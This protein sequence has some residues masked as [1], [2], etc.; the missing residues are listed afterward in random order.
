MP[1]R[2]D[3]PSY[4]P[5]R[6]VFDIL[7]EQMPVGKY[8][9]LGYWTPTGYWRFQVGNDAENVGGFR[10]T[11]REQATDP[12]LAIKQWEEFRARLNDLCGTMSAVSLM[13]LRQDAGFL[14]TTAGGA[15]FVMTHPWV[16]PELPLVFESLHET[17]DKIVTEPFLRNW[18]DTMC[19]FCGF[20]A[21]GAMTAHILYILD[22]FFVDDACHSAV[23][24]PL[25]LAVGATQRAPCASSARAW[26]LLAVWH[27]Q[28]E[29]RPLGASP[30][31]QLL[32][33]AASKVADFTAFERAGDLASALAHD[34]QAHARA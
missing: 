13:N 19:I 1:R 33:R 34:A 3:Q 2:L 17:V 25:P 18:I 7:D 27:S 30:R 22:R 4:N 23:K 20:P 6:I 26:W 24:V 32:K 31:P 11:L 10:Q 29:A 9:G 28:S 14:A 12:E 21:K 16:L 8:Y 15:P 5:L